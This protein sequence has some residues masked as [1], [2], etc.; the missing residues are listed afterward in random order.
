MWTDSV[1]HKR[2]R[3][4]NAIFKSRKL[5]SK[6]L[7]CIIPFID[8]PFSMQS[9]LQYGEEAKTLV[10]VKTFAGTLKDLEAYIKY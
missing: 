2:G 1:G 7:V 5:I 9:K 8:H 10:L 3:T 4:Y 6:K